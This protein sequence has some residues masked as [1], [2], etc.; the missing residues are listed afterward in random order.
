MPA[1]QVEFP[2]SARQSVAHGL[3]VVANMR[4]VRR[5]PRA[6]PAS[7]WRRRL[8]GA[9]NILALM[10]LA[11]VYAWRNRVGWR[12]WQRRHPVRQR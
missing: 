7:I 9:R 3:D 11:A 4:D 5:A 10:A 1:Q 12:R 6:R 8:A 2:R